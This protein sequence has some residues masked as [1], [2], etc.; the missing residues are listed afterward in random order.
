MLGSCRPVGSVGLAPIPITAILAV[1]DEYGYEESVKHY[2]ETVNDDGSI[3]YES[4]DEPERARF[5]HAIR[6]IDREQCSLAAKRYEKESK[7]K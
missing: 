7:K 1:A 6:K 3:E 2:I 4:F 5:I